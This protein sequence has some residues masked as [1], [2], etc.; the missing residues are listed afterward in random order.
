VEPTAAIL[1]VHPNTVK[2]RIRR[3]TELT[4]FDA[5]ASADDALDYAMRWWWALGAWLSATAHGG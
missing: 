2:Y 5:T 4:P 3:L 1:H